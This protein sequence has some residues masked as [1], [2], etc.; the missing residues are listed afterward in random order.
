MFDYS[1][2]LARVQ[3]TMAAQGVDLLFLNASTNLQYLTGIPRDEPNYGNTMYPGEWLTG[4]WVPQQGAPILTL[5]RML[6]DFHLG[7][8]PGYDVRVL[9]DAGD[10]AA[11][12]RDVLT[13]LRTPEQAHIAVDDRSWAELVLNVQKLRPA[14]TLS[15]A[16]A[17]LAPLR[18]IKDEDEIAVMRK[19]GEITEAAYAATLPQLKHGMTN[20]DLITEVNYQLRK[21]GSRA[22]S[23]VTAFYNMGRNYPFDFTNREEVLQIPLEPPVS[24]SFDFGAVYAGYCYDFGRSV[25]FGEPDEEY[26]RVHALVMASQAAGIAALRAGGTCQAADAAAR[27]VIAEGGYGHAFRH[28]LGH[29]IGM[30]VH[31]PPFLTA[32]DATVLEAGMCFTVEPSIFLP[33]HL[34]ARVEDVVVVRGDGGEA[35]TRGFQGLHVVA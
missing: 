4:A 24:V 11:L 30:D 17:I 20:L 19:A 32:G 35:L 33:R 7:A 22:P 3:Q 16:S 27:Q 10:A 18:R 9:P 15:Q 25:F 5:P 13:A 34:G 8:I 28:R 6:A 21:H 26:R 14:A 12:A 23:F 31:E 29:G 2:R 1:Q